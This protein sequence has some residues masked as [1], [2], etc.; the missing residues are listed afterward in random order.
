MKQEKGGDAPPP[1]QPQKREVTPLQ[2]ALRQSKKDVDAVQSTLSAGKSLLKSMAKEKEWAW[3][4]TP[5]A[6]G[7]L[8]LALDTVDEDVESC[9]LA[10]L[11][12]SGFKQNQARP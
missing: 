6:Q 3:A 4:R 11:L 12:T 9:Q 5:Q 8:K 7:A 2:K 10:M 1:L